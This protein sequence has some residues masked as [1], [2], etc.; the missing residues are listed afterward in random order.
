MRIVIS[1]ILV[2]WTAMRPLT[3]SEELHRQLTVSKVLFGWTFQ[4]LRV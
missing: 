3:L 4:A 1:R 2:I